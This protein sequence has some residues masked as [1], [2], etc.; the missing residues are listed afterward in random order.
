M[1]WSLVNGSKLAV[2]GKS[3]N[4]ELDEEYVSGETGQSEAHVVM[5]KPL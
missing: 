3:R 1:L 2:F 4:P 5:V